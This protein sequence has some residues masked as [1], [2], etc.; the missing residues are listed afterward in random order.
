M[1]AVIGVALNI[2]PR[3]MP[4]HYNLTIDLE[5]LFRNILIY[6]YKMEQLN[7]ANKRPKT[8]R[9]DHEREYKAHVDKLDSKE[10]E[11][12]ERLSDLDKRKL[13][14][15]EANGNINVS[16]DDVVEIN[17]GG[18]IISAKRST[19]T[20]LKGTRVEALFSGRWDNKLQRDSNERIFL[21]V[22]PVCFQAIVDFLNEL[23]ISSEDD[24]PSPPSV[25]EE[26]EHILKHQLDLFGM[27]QG[28]MSESNIIMDKKHATQLRDWL[29]EDGSD[30]EFSLLYRSSSDGL[31]AEAFHSN[32][33]NQGCTL[34]VI[35]TTGGLVL[36]GYSNTPWRS[37]SGSGWA[38]ADK[39][40]LL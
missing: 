8:P 33:D 11:L 26:H 22:N 39:A 36:G 19:L 30:G 24:P 34:T 18:M 17:S 28:E 7:I 31:S 23:T 6:E 12:L 37:P 4:H 1:N 21:D 2:S 25:D 27:R 5:P 9:D 14:T 13:E 35:E 38:A 40:F 3:L 29:E 20:Q 32:C 15:A 10:R 16:D